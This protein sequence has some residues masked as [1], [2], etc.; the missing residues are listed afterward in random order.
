MSSVDA[1]FVG[2]CTSVVIAAVYSVGARTCTDVTAVK[3]LRR[4]ALI[5]LV[6][7]VTLSVVSVF[8]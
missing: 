8:A 7:A 6:T 5:W 3:D 4:W 1:L 2:S